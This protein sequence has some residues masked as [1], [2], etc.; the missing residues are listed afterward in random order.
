MIGA[1]Y[2]R[3]RLLSSA[4]QAGCCQRVFAGDSERYCIGSTARNH[5][6]FASLRMTTS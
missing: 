2:N 6:F 5:R 1:R 3:C 4:H